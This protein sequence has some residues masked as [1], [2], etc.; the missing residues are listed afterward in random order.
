MVQN[1]LD[2]QAAK[3]ITAMHLA[4]TKRFLARV[5]KESKSKSI[6]ELS[7]RLPNWRDSMTGKLSARNISAHVSGVVMFRFNGSGTK[8]C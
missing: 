2:H 6:E 8:E 1:Y 4:N 3:G 5:I 7:D